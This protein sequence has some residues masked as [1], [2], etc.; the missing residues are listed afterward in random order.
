[1]NQNSNSVPGFNAGLSL[2]VSNKT[3]TKT[4]TERHSS[5]YKT[6]GKSPVTLAQLGQCLDGSDPIPPGPG[7]QCYWWSGSGPCSPC[8]TT[9]D[10]YQYKVCLEYSLLARG[11]CKKFLPCADLIVGEPQCSIRC[12]QHRWCCPNGV[13]SPECCLQYKACCSGIG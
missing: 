9:M 1:V 12:P 10:G 6:V 5:K 4:G 8:Y 3:K 2:L 7:G 13:N 11:C